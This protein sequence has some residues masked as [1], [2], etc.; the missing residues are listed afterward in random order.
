ME[1]NTMKNIKKNMLKVL[2]LVALLCP[3][4]FADPGDMGGGG[5]ANY[6]APVKSAET[7]N[8]DGDMGGGGLAAETKSYLESVLDAVCDY[9]DVAI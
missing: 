4:A 1:K 2:V 9:F 7:T 3:V 5:F 8:L 6:D